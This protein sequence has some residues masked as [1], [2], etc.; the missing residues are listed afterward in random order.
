MQQ[1]KFKWRNL[2]FFMSTP[3]IA[4]VG[5]PYYLYHYDLSSFDIALFIFYMYATGLSITMGYHRLFAHST[6]KANPFVRFFL[7]FFGA[8]AFEQSVLEWASQHRDHHLYVD[9]Q[10]DPYNIKQGFWY[11]HL[12]WIFRWRNN[13]YSNV[14]D[15][16]KD[17]IIQSQHNHYMFWAIG[18][19]VLTPILLSYIGGGSMLAA[20]I[21]SV[22][23]RL[24]FVHH[25]TFFINS[26]CH[27]F[28]KTTYDDK[29]TAKDHWFVAML[30]NGEGYHNFHHRF[31]GDFRNGVRWYHWDP[32][33]WF[34]GLL[35][36]IGLAWDVRRI[37]RFRILEARIEAEKQR[38]INELA[39]LGTDHHLSFQEKVND[40]F[41]MLK[42]KL[43]A[44]DQAVSEF[45]KKR[46]EHR[47]NKEAKKLLGTIRKDVYQARQGF[48]Q[49]YNQWIRFVKNDLGM[50]FAV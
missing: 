24:T 49:E 20:F 46:Q 30:T 47:S 38:V 5:V 44:W 1:Q 33:K 25:S 37:S 28:G 19:G 32:S 9:T 6:Y 18:T 4:L 11:A 26:V 42:N 36:N 13:E 16:Q 27:T 35:E 48:L 2:I 34:I 21:F 31:P 50:A 41:N 10:K 29:S 45:N 23:L 40:I 7:I 39:L 12:G 14:K 8:A 43:A 15:L 22:A 17:P 3:A